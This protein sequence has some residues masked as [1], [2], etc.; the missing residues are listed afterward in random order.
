MTTF[1]IAFY[2]SYLSTLYSKCLK[3]NN[4]LLSERT[5]AS[6]FCARRTFSL[7]IFPFWTKRKIFFLLL[8]FTSKELIFNVKFFLADGISWSSSVVPPLRS[9]AEQTRVWAHGSACSAAPASAANHMQGVRHIIKYECY[10]QCKALE[11][12]QYKHPMPT[13]HLQELKL[14]LVFC[15]V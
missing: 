13:S 5:R 12:C 14:C 10:T 7:H 9:C 4:N 6:N 2:E 1:C 11:L 8:T 15:S 3:N